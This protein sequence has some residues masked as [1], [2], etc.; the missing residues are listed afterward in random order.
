MWSRIAMVA[1]H[2]PAQ[3]FNSDVVVSTQQKQ[4]KATPQHKDKLGRLIQLDDFVAYPQSNG[5]RVGK[6][7]KLNN[8]MVKVLDITK[9]SK[10]KPS[11]YNKYPH[12]VV[13]LEQ[14]DMTWYILKNS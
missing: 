14:S 12:D 13:K 8:K 11:E 2:A 1:G 5:L 9:P 7:I 3:D 4:P 6:I 10:Y